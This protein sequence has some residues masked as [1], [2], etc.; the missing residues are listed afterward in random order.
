MSETERRYNVH[1]SVEVEADPAEVWE[2]VTDDDERAEWFGGPTRMTPAV[3]SEASFTE[4]D[5]TERHGVVDSVVPGRHIGWTWWD[6]EGT[7]SR[8]TI[9]VSP[10][11]A[12]T[13]VDVV[14]TLASATPKNSVPGLVGGAR[15][16]ELEHRFLLRA[17]TLTV[18]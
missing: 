3:G 2:A 8:V 17:A 12:G 1:R 14:E 6:D 15:M 4:P 11:P 7:A 5:G 16:L 9:D 10:S 18:A 13:R